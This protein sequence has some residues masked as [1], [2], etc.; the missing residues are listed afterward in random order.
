MNDYKCV[1]GIVHEL[2]M[3]T[4]VPTE[5]KQNHITELNSMVGKKSGSFQEI[6]PKKLRELEKNS[7]KNSDFSKH[8]KEA[9][10]M[11][12]GNLAP[13][14]DILHGITKNQNTVQYLAQKASKLS[15]TTTHC[16]SIFPKICNF[17]NSIKK[18]REMI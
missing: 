5:L 10:A 4:S 1:L 17:T 6:P 3:N 9:S 14:L 8:Y 18:T 15:A 13:M 16:E 2:T 11:D 7:E 12:S